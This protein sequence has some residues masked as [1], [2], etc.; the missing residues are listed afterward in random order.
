MNTFRRNDLLKK[1]VEHYHSCPHVHEI[2]VVWS[3]LANAPP[4]RS[5]FKLPTNGKVGGYSTRGGR[6]CCNDSLRLPTTTTSY[7]A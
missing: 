4:E 2:Q 7:I 1:T 5:F 6:V 3:D